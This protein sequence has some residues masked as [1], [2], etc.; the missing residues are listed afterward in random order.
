[1]KK[2][3]GG[4]KESF[5]LRVLIVTIVCTK[6]PRPNNPHPLHFQTTSRSASSR[7]GDPLAKGKIVVEIWLPVPPSS[8]TLPFLCWP[9]HLASAGRPSRG[10]FISNFDPLAV[11][12]TASVPERKSPSA[13]SQTRNCLK[14]QKT[15]VE[16]IATRDPL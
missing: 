3:S 6:H 1:M 11:R 16:S 7:Q 5:F 9:S 15:M 13:V 2:V 12:G 14:R 4:T 8:A 10:T